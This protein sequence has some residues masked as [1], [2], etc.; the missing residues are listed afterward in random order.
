M[1]CDSDALLQ[2]RAAVPRRALMM[3]QRWESLLFLHWIVDRDELQ[4]TLPAGLQVDTCAEKAYVGLTPFFVRNLR[5]PKLPSLPWV[6]HFLELN[7]RTYVKDRF[8]VPGIWF[9]SLDCSRALGVLGARLWL[10]L[11]YHFAEMDAEA[12]AEMNYRSRRRGTR[13]CAR[14]RYRVI[15][16][17]WQTEPGTLDFFL[18]ERYYLYAKR[19]NTGP[20][21][22]VQVQHKPYELRRVDVTEWSAIPLQLDGFSQLQT[23]PVHACFVDGFDVKVYG[24]E[25]I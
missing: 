2:A 14:Y 11:P 10:G 13:P 8:G 18:L 20:L 7:V 23:A 3:H 25:K 15:G 16:P 12:A 4:R 21:L 17:E 19:S 6:S 22:R 5:P 24:I 9:Y 1:T